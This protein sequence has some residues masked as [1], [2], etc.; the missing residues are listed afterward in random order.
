MCRR[1]GPNQGKRWEFLLPPP[2]L[3]LLL[4]RSPF[5]RTW[6]GGRNQV[7]RAHHLFPSLCSFLRMPR[8]LTLILDC[9]A[10]RFVCERGGPRRRAQKRKVQPPHDGRQPVS[11]HHNRIRIRMPSIG[12]PD[13]IGIPDSPLCIA[14]FAPTPTKRFALQTPP[15]QQAT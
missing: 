3:S 15:R 2:C 5:V 10:S 7:P 11:T 4:L 8:S 14:S 13:G 6:R 12:I 9:L 1:D